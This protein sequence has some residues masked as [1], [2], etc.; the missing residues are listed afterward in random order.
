MPATLRACQRRRAYAPRV[1]PPSM[2]MVVP[3]M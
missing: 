3:L 1:A 2:L